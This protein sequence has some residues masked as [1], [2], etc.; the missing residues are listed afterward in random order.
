MLAV[1][2]SACGLRQQHLM[3]AIGARPAETEVLQL[4]RKVP[5][6]CSRQRCLL[7]QASTACLPGFV[8]VLSRFC[9][10]SLHLVH[11]LVALLR[12]SIVLQF[13]L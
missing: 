7:L 6:L 10:V 1:T 11:E 2:H 13:F 12:G 5:T 4:A 9:C 3:C 8:T